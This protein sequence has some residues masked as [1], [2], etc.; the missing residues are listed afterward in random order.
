MQESS[1]QYLQKTPPNNIKEQ[2][3]V[4]CD[5]PEFFWDFGPELC[6]CQ[7]WTTILSY[8]NSVLPSCTAGRAFPVGSILHLANGNAAR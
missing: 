2:T 8:N 1:L 5:I 7:L 6:S 3:P 4:W